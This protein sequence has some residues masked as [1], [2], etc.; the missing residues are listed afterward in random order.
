M[1]LCTLAGVP[2]TIDP[3]S[4]SWDYTPRVSEIN[5]VGGKVIQVYGAYLG[6]MLVSGWFGAG[7]FQDQQK[8]LDRMK[9]ISLSQEIKP[10]ARGGDPVKFA[11]PAKGWDFLVFLKAYSSGA[12]NRSVNLRNEILHN[13]RWNLT[14][15]I[16]EE[17]LGLKAASQDLFIQRLSDGLGWSYR[18][19]GPMEPADVAMAENGMTL[20][21]YEK[22]QLASFQ[23]PP[24]TTPTP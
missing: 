23:T 10:G 11:Y 24:D 22:Q 6:D 1:G 5:T 14:L 4:V 19:H 20:L 12:G 21:D 3:E 2:F 7:G 16:S 18:Y 13:L 17:N 15:T 8:F 9:A